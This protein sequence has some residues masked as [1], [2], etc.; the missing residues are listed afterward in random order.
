MNSPSHVA[1]EAL[2]KAEVAQGDAMTALRKADEAHG[3]ANGA[4]AKI[5]AHE[6]LCAE[7]YSAIDQTLTDL[8][9]LMK[10]FGSIIIVTMIS[11]MG[12]LITHQNDAID[13]KA[14]DAAAEIRQLRQDII[15]AQR[16]A[17]D[18]P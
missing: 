7:R 9:G 14:S 1:Y 5:E 4:D 10:W 12:Y 13:K 17:P 11:A 15:A 16:H 18:Q 2:I 8:K 3:L 6:A